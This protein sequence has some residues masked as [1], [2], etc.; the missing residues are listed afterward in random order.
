MIPKTGC[1]PGLEIVPLSSPKAAKILQNLQT[2]LYD[3]TTFPR[4]PLRITPRTSYENNFL[5][6][7]HEG[8][9]KIRGHLSNGNEPNV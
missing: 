9:M 2:Q 3:A 8:Q 6:H 4:E 1:F 7:P 5:Q